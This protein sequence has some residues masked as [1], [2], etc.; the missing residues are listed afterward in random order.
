VAMTGSLATSARA[1]ELAVALARC[2]V[3]PQ[4]GND[5]ADRLANAHADVAAL[6]PGR[7]VLQIGMDTPQVSPELLTE[8][9]EWLHTKDVDAVLG[10]ALDGG[11]WGLGLRSPSDARVLRAVP[12]SRSDT[13]ART[14]VALR[15]IGLRVRSLRQL[16]DVDTMADA[17]RVA[18]TAPGGRFA[19]GVR[20]LAGVRRAHAGV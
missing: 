9:I 2:T 7:P 16:S 3:I 14:L 8:S 15:R 5:F 10:P 19:A 4:W 17:L 18:D 13:G 12:M 1:G 11:W 20:E 6:Y